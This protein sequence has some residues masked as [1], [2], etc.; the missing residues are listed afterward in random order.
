MVPGPE[1]TP[2]GVARTSQEEQDRHA[3]GKF[4]NCHWSGLYKGPMCNQE[5]LF[6]L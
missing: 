1:Q 5:L 6:G 3:E 2:P 4:C